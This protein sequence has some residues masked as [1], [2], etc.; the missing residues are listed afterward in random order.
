VYTADLVINALGTEF[1]VK[2]YPEEDFVET[3]L[4]SGLVTLREQMKVPGV[5]K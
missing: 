4:V 5:I 1:N 2:A 3:T